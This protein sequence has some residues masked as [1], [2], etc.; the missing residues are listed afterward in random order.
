MFTGSYP[1]I[2]IGC[3]LTCFQFLQKKTVSTLPNTLPA[4]IYAR[5]KID[6]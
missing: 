1:R 3:Q 2:Y 5:G 6:S 4:R